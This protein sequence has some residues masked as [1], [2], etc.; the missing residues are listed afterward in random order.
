MN[1]ISSDKHVQE[2]HKALE[3]MRASPY[4]R[5]FE[6]RAYDSY[7]DRYKFPIA[8]LEDVGIEKICEMVEH[9]WSL[10]K[11]AKALDLSVRVLR[12]WVA[13]DPVYQRD[14]EQAE[15]WSADEYMDKA[16]DV[17]LNAPLMP[18]ALTKAKA[19]QGHCELRAKFLNKEKYGTTN[20]KLDATVNQGVS[21][22]FNILPQPKLKEAI[23]GS[24]EE[25]PQLTE[26]DKETTS[27]LLNVIEAL[28]HE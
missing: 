10:T 4:F 3:Q 26:E 23:E 24:F 20:V 2:Q 16:E 21:Y 28:E 19:L 5:H 17:L 12:R 1:S 7:F 13:N 14:M 11:I 15:R 22:V 25:V 8:F 18:E 27:R 9:G 6:P